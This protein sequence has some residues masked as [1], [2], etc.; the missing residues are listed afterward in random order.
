PTGA[1]RIIEDVD[2]AVARDCLAKR[3]VSSAF[4]ANRYSGWSASLFRKN[5]D[6]AGQR[7]RT[8]DSAL[9]TAGDFDPVDVVRREV[10]KIELAGQ[11]LIDRNAI[12]Q[13]LHVLARQTAQ[14][15]RGQLTGSSSLNDGK[16]RNFTQRVG[17]AFDLF[18][19]DLLRINHRHAGG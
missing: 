3:A 7:A 11:S 15:N 6:H 18:V 4:L 9:R 19:V 17:H 10:G 14:E 5:L 1:D 13:D 2:L 12:E 8:V 16:S